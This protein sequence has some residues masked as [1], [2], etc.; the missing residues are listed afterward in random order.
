MSAGETATWGDVPPVPPELLDAFKGF[1]ET[2]E[3]RTLQNITLDRATVA[4]KRLARDK[5]VDRDAIEL[6][7]ADLVGMADLLAGAGDAA[8]SYATGALGLHVLERLA[9]ELADKLKA[10][11]GEK[12]EAV[13]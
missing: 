10:A 12:A 6:V 1:V 7:V 8:E 13:P 4:A 9:H 2:V 5:L 3:R 11:I